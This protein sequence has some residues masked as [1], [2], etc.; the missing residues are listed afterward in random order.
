MSRISQMAHMARR[1][2][3]LADNSTH[4]EAPLPPIFDNCTQVLSKENE[5]EARDLYWDVICTKT[6]RDRH[7]EAEEQL[8][9]AVTLNPWIGE[10]H[11]LLA[12][13]YNASG[14]FEQAEEHAKKALKA[15]FAWA[16]AWDKRVTWDGWVAWAR[17]QLA[18]ARARQWPTQAFGIINLGLV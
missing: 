8:L 9:K 10:P 18:Q 5:R 15:L 3:E 14:R 11:V 13:I 7:N 4:D 1:C 12:Q 2:E 6:E 17:I 16:T